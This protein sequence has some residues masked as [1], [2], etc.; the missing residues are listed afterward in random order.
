MI[1]EKIFLIIGIVII[2][3][4]IIG[5]SFT[6]SGSE[7]QTLKVGA[8]VPLTGSFSTL[9]ERIQ[10][11]LV[12]AKEN[13]EKND[14]IKIDLVFEDVCQGKDAVPAMN[15]MIQVDKIQMLGASFCLVGFVPIIP[16]AQENKI[17]AFNTATNPDMVLNN[18][19]VFST[20]KAIKD[21]AQ[22]QVNIAITK[23]NTKKAALIYYTTPLGLDYGKY[24]RK[25]FE[26]SNGTIVFDQQVDLSATDFKTELTKIKEQNPD[27]IFVTHLAASLGNFLKQAREL[28]ITAYII[29][30]SEA[31][32]P[33]VLNT[34]GLA[35]EGFI[36]SSAEPKEKTN[37]MLEFQKDYNARFGSLPDVLEAN[38]YDALHLEV[39]VYQKCSGVVECM[40]KELHNVKDYPCVSGLIT[41]NQDGAANKPNMFKIVENGKFVEYKE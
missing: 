40:Q 30:N 31:E 4:I 38:A 6:Y 29:S 39:Y 35:A 37:Y 24:Q 23:L 12:L 27:V 34:A 3:A 25:Y 11:G 32:D 14:N 18:P 36:V 21:D 7:K 15:K 16:I 20:N 13:I 26:D 17:I 9:G 33:N 22:K 28:D 1:K 5:I 10:N 41:I 8:L 19:F 2:L